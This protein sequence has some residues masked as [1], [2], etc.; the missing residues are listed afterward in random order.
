MN[1]Y[2]ISQTVNYGYDVYDSAVVSAIDEDG[3]RSIHPGGS[4][5]QED[6]DNGDTGHCWCKKEDVIVEEIGTC[7]SEKSEVI[8]ASFIGG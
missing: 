4:L 3:V 8:C 6:Y 1:L 2:L 7:I 5:Y